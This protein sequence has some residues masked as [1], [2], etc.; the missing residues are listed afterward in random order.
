MTHITESGTARLPRLLAL[1]MALTPDAL[2]ASVAAKALNHALAAQ[3]ARDELDFLAGRRVLLH[4]QDAG[5]KLTLTLSAGALAP[6]RGEPDLAVR[7]SL[8]EFMLLAARRVDPDMLFFQRRLRME[9]DTELGLGLKN[10]LAALE[11]D[12]VALLRPLDLVLQRSLPLYRR[13]FG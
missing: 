8:Y 11:D 2:H 4:I 3:L 10:F 7:G 5:V 6:A 13:L 1:P 12:E 9:G